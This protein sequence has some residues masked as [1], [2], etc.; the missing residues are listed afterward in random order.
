MTELLNIKFILLIILGFSF[1]SC[2]K[3]LDEPSNPTK[4]YPTSIANCQALLDNAEVMNEGTTPGFVDASCD[5][6]FLTQNQYTSGNYITR[7][8]YLWKDPFTGTANDWVIGYAPIYISNVCLQY[9]D[10]IE[11]SENIA[12]WNN[13]K[14]SALFFRAYYFLQLVWEYGKAYDNATADQDLGI[15]LKSNV[16]LYAP[17]VRSTV[18]QTY[19]QIIRDA[20]QALLYLPDNA[21]HPLRPSKA[22]AYGLL[23]RTYLSMRLYDDALLY[24]D[25]CLGLKNSLLDY[26]GDVDL[27]ANINSATS[28]FRLYNKETIF[29]SHAAQDIDIPHVS[30]SYVDTLLYSSYQP[31]DLRKVAFFLK[32]ADTSYR[33]FK[34][35]YSQNYI[36]HFS[37][38]ATDEIFLIRSECYARKG[39][40]AQA[41][42]DLN[43]LMR[44][45]WKNSVTY[46][47]IVATTPDEALRFVLNE[48]RK[49]LLMRGLRWADIKRLN[50]EANHF[51]IPKRFINNQLDSLPPNDNRYALPIPLAVIQQTSVQQNPR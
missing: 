36:K 28:P 25:K 50:K 44:K 26:N 43:T 42:D 18:R 33:T 31:D 40:L 9:I 8:V 11:K 4:G 46:P 51:I 19:E 17:T 3:Y 49:E 13:V 39:Q 48:R 14:G 23:A 2:K 30:T 29:Y 47:V 32:G 24:S 7:D 41:L 35:T 27:V 1:A 45:R 6:Y 16:D 15:A 12:G 10:G 22:A 37:G 20:K 21:N 38:I 5:D 34:G